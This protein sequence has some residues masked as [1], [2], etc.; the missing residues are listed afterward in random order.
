MNNKWKVALKFWKGRHE[1]EREKKWK[2]KKRSCQTEWLVVT[3]IA[4]HGGE[5][6]TIP[7]PLRKVV[8]DNWIALQISPEGHGAAHLLTR[9]TQELTILLII[10]IF[11]KL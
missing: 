5:V 1:H 2:K 6:E 3:C 10:F 4:H 8:F 9:A 7:I 11:S